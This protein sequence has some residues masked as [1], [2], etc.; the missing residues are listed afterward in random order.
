[1]MMFGWVFMVALIMLI[2]WVIR[3]ESWPRDAGPRRKGAQE[4][5]ADRFARGEINQ[6]EYL[7]RKS[8]LVEGG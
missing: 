6:E 1:M 7:R 3:S 5:L 8:D 2:F 4:I